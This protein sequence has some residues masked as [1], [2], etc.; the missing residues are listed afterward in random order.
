LIGSNIRRLLGFAP[1]RL[2][3][4]LVFDRPERGCPELESLADPGGVCISWKVH[5]EIG[6]KLALS[7]DYL[8][9]QWVKNIAEPVRVFRV[10]LEPGV[11]AVFGRQ[12]T[13]IIRKLGATS[14]C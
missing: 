7:Y 4:R 1:E 8:G 9:A 13:R 12:K 11:F 14:P 6:N 10:V 3:A 5:E 2:Q